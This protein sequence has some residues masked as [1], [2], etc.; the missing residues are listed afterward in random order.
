MLAYRCHP[1]IVVLR[2]FRPYF[3][4]TIVYSAFSCCCQF[5]AHYLKRENGGKVFPYSDCQRTAFYAARQAV[6][7]VVFPLFDA[8]DVFFD[9]FGGVAGHAVE[10]GEVVEAGDA[11]GSNGA[12][13]FH[14]GLFALGADA[15]YFV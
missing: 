15:G 5:V 12:E 10:G 2:G 11:D 4:C 9:F 14:E 13:V 1:S 3:V 7:K 8:P 6:G